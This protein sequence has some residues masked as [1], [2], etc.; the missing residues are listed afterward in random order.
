MGA[1][2]PV[3]CLVNTTLNA[4]QWFQHQTPSRTGT[5]PVSVGWLW[6]CSTDGWS[7]LPYNWTGACALAWLHLSGYI[8]EILGARLA[9]RPAMHARWG[10]N[11]CVAW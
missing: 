9:N 7:Y 2:T 5:Y 4:T 6:T 8:R 1:L 10:R 11:K 3:D